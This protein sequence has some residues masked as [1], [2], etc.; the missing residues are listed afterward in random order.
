MHGPT[1]MANPLACA[2]GNASLDLFESEPRLKQVAAIE[3]QLR[4]AFAPA[5]EIPG[6]VD[7]RVKGAIGVI[8][9]AKLH[10]RDRLHQRFLDAGVFVRPFADM[11]YV[12]PP[13]TITSAQL[14][15][16]CEARDRRHTRVGEV[17]RLVGSRATSMTVSLAPSLPRESPT[18]SRA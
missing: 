6:V 7:V 2:A 1:Y 8:Q 4:D 18:C 5:T 3:S 15:Q 9:V 10:H 11:I 14:T 12:T 16:L 13:L 17:G